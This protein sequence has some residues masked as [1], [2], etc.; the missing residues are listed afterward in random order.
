MMRAVEELLDEVENTHDG[1][2]PDPLA[3]VDDPA[4]ARIA[5]QIRVRADERALDETAMAAREVGLSWQAIGNV[6][7]MTFQGAN[8]RLHTA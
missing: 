2:R 8:K 4:P 6:L 3:T 5:A 1:E 7:S